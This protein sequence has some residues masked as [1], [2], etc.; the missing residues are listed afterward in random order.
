MDKK[1]TLLGFV[2]VI[3]LSPVIFWGC[4]AKPV[5][6]MRPLYTSPI[7][8][9]AMVTFK[10][11]APNAGAVYLVGDFNDWKISPDYKLSN[12]PNGIWL[13]SV[14]IGPGS[15]KYAF[16]VDGQQRM[17]DANNDAVGDGSGGRVSVLTIQ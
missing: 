1:R 6:P 11:W 4:A 2:L 16:S 12:T 5:M 9:G 13:T 8:E 14:R 15:Y 10:I 3:I 17:D 7:V